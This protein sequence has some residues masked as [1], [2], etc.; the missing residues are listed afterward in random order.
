MILSFRYLQEK[1][2]IWR[3]SIHCPNKEQR[4]SN[5]AQDPYAAAQ[6]FKLII[7]AVLK[8]LLGVEVVKSRVKTKMG[9]LGLVKC[10]FGLVECQGWGTLHLHIKIWLDDL[11]SS[12]DMMEELKK[13]EFREKLQEYIRKNIHAQG[14]GLIL[15]DDARSTP[16][17]KCTYL[18]LAK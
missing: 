2:L 5:I 16:V 18:R 15:A 17:V 3:T 6:Y 12:N 13:P 7:D 9:I 14:P 11:L 8:H 10:Y 1:I 4:S